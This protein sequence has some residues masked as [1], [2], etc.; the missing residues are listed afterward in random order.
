M[1]NSNFSSHP[2]SSR[3]WTRSI[4][5]HRNLVYGLI[6]VIALLGFE[7][8]N[9]STTQYALTDLLGDIR[10]L[11]ISWST[12]LSIAFCGIDFAGVARLFSGDPIESKA[13]EIWFL[14]GA[15]LLAATLNATLTWW[16]VSMALVNHKLM[17]V[18]VVDPNT[19]VKVVPMFVAVAV[20]VTRILLISSISSAGSR[21]LS[22]EYRDNPQA[23]YLV[24]HPRARVD[25]PT[26]RPQRAYSTSSPQI[27]P[28][29]APKPAAPTPAPKPEARRKQPV[30]KAPLE[31]PEYVPD[32]SYIPISAY[33]SLSAREDASNE[34]PRN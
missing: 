30:E 4:I 18:A 9:Y 27:S 32:P 10:F 13:K 19:L 11:G 26:A 31:E 34:S 28:R 23:S 3:N 20:W 1:N 15:W 17:S 16:G 12:I 24:E 5:N 2:Y 29:P 21:F 8:F 22:A 25:E 14:F 6:L 7:M 33:H